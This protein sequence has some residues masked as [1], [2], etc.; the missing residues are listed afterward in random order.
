MQQATKTVFTTGAGTRETTCL[1]VFCWLLGHHAYRN[2][3]K[4]KFQHGGIFSGYQARS[5]VHASHFDYRGRT[6]V[7]KGVPHAK[8]NWDCCFFCESLSARLGT[9]EPQAYRVHTPVRNTV[10]AT[11]PTCN[12]LSPIGASSCKVATNDIRQPSSTSILQ[13]H[14]HPIRTGRRYSNPAAGSGLA[15]SVG[16]QVQDQVYP[17]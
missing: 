8:Y 6:L 4:W 13:V 9:H 16:K 1:C 11:L 5:S 15:G 12:C 7:L 10:R 3:P 14:L 2:A 17:Q